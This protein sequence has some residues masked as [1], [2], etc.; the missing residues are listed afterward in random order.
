M[1]S[2]A[3]IQCVEPI[4]N[5]LSVNTDDIRLNRPGIYALKIMNQRTTRIDDAS[6]DA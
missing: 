2:N 5:R 3:F 1:R 4:K 6:A